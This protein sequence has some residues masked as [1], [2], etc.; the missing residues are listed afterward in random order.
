MIRIA[1][2]WAMMIL[3]SCNFKEKQINPEQV[4]AIPR[5]SDT[6]PNGQR[7][8]N[9]TDSSM[10]FYYRE[11]VGPDSLTGGYVTCYGTDD[12]LIY[13]YLRHGDTLHLLNKI[14]TYTTAW[15]VGTL[16]EDFDS[17]FI[18]RIDNGNGVPGTFQVFEKK[19]GKNLLGDEVEAM[20]YQVYNDS[21][22]FLYDNHTVKSIGNLIDRK[23]ADSIFLYNV[24][25]GRHEG[26]RLPVEM[27]H[28]SFIE[29]KK[30]TKNALTISWVQIM[31]KDAEKLVKYKR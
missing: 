15:A 24:T 12:S 21:L 6:L 30:I 20:N 26:F 19:T 8:V 1:L 27:P 11:I 25:S 4:A 9:N 3:L 22:Y 23:P 16:E 13:L 2:I 29:L 7:E 5:N 18:T 14:P 10:D 17:F 31:T 28:D